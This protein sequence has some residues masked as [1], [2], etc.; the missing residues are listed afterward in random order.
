MAKDQYK[1]FRIEARELLEGLNQGVLEFERGSRDKDLVGRILRLA[2]TLKGA[3]RVVKQP[4]I[5]EL[6]HSIEDAFAPLREDKGEVPGERINQVLDFLDR[7]AIKVA[8][9]E[10]V[11]AEGRGET[12]LPVSEEVFET[13][14]VEVEEIDALLDGVSEASVQITALRQVSETAVRAGQLASILFAS[15]AQRPKLESSGSEQTDVNAKACALAEELRGHL[16]RL[17]PSLVAGVEEVAAE[18]AQVREATNRLR[19]LSAATVFPSLERAVRDAAQSLHKE[20]R[21]ESSGGDIRLD[22]HVL[23]AL[24][25]ALLHVV[26]N[27]VAHGIESLPERRAAGKPL[28]GR[29]ELQVERRGSRAAFICRDDGRGIDVEAVRRAA[30]QRGLVATSEATSLGLEEA[31]RIIMKGGV[32]TTTSV[33][34]VSGRGI[35]LDVVRETAA[36]LRGEVTVRSETGIGTSF[37]MCVPVSVSSL[38]AL[39]VDA[40]GTIASL[41]LDAV[42]QTLRVA[43]CDIAHS[44]GTD[45]I[46]YDGRAI[47]F[48]PLTRVFGKKMVMERKLKSWSAVVLEA[49]TGVVAIGVDRLLGAA[50]I[51][52]RPLPPL[53]AADPIVAGVSLDPEGDPQLVLDPERLVA[54]ACVGMAPGL[55][56]VSGKRPPVLV[57][58][59]SLTTRMLERNILESAGYDVDLTTSGEEALGKA[60]EKQYG[61]FLVDVEMPGMDGFEFVSRTQADAVLRAVPSILVTSRNAAEDRRRGEQVG[62]RAYIVKGDFDQ[63]FLLQKIREFIG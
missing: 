61:L 23:T 18:F 58:D 13:V 41:P 35:G 25:D 55:E 46:V 29:V 31:V 2:H 53:A 30:I 45:S 56:P 62:A 47:P 16:E 37:E 63:G 19:L 44:A 26:R 60:H 38:T 40:G 49:S 33:D 43:D 21:F 14:R 27:A 6:A 8:S 24:R 3:S 10:I 12:P 9:L 32:T 42:R 54:A 52:V 34:E 7:I 4:E 28:R 11:S 22:T 1:Y 15:Q 59:D 36:R 20:I 5:A 48:L 17:G 57:I 51:V 50:T 39:E